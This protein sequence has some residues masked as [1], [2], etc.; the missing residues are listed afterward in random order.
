MHVVVY[1]LYF[2][3]NIV[4]SA[5]VKGS[6]MHLNWLPNP[7]PRR[8]G[9]RETSPVFDGKKH[10]GHTECIE[11]EVPGIRI[12]SLQLTVV[13]KPYQAKPATYSPVACIS[14]GHIICIY[15]VFV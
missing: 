4:G 6:F 14:A 15:L 5:V 8:P 3:L 13:C 10:A 9:S 12:A 11:F 2:E 1:P 7:N